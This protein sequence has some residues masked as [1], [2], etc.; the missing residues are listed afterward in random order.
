M[1]LEFQGRY[2]LAL[3]PQPL[4]RCLGTARAQTHLPSCC[5]TT[6][7]LLGGAVQEWLDQGGLGASP[8]HVL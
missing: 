1:V 6:Q 4:S 3:L 2:L 8:L 7:W 5:P